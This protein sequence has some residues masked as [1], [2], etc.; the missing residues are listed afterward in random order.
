MMVWSFKL[1]KRK[2]IFGLI[3]LAAIIAVVLIATGRSADIG[4]EQQPQPVTDNSAKTPEQLLAFIS[5]FGW[6]VQ[7]EPIQV[8]S[9]YIPRNFDEV[10]TR[11][12]AVQKNQ[13]YDLQQYGGQKATRYT[14]L[15][16]NY[17][18]A[19]GEVVINILVYEGTV[20]GGDVCS[21]QLGGFM[22]GFAP[23]RV[24]AGEASADGS[25]QPAV[26]P[27]GEQQSQVAAMPDGQSQTQTVIADEI[28]APTD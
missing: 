10:L 18:D 3:A 5:Q 13:G 28:S 23:D 24:T 1:S 4:T 9:V 27:D 14:Y 6:E 16:T 15:V 11:Y 17:P 12:N 22:H 26:Q 21:K 2:I 25:A 19:D 20:I 7:P 8:L